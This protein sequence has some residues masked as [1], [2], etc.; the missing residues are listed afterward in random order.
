MRTRAEWT[1]KIL[2]D[3]AKAW[4][5]VE[6]KEG[7]VTDVNE[8][9]GMGVRSCEMIVSGEAETLGEGMAHVVLMLTWI[10]ETA[11]ARDEKK[12]AAS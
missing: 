11:I 1:E 3:L 10:R 7:P 12:A 5:H 4:K 2:A 8:A 6:E 9:W